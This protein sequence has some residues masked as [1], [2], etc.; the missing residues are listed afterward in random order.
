MAAMAEE[1]VEKRK[2]GKR[3]ASAPAAIPL[4]AALSATVESPLG[5]LLVSANEDAVLALGWTGQERREPAAPLLAEA[6]RQLSAYFAGRLTRF[7][8]PLAPEGSS[9]DQRVRRA[10]CAIPYG[11]TATYGAIA[12]A[13]GS[14][15][16][17]VGGACGRNP[18]PILIPCHR[19]VAGAGLGG[20][21]GGEGLTTKA[22]L[23]AFEG[24]RRAGR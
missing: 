2:F 14:S 7:D 15:P 9:F 16:R 6:V 19:I 10:M 20:Y 3:A 13:I 11:E 4:S 12:R 18:V 17:A 24:A 5:R 21:S 22:W 8:L 23:L 1:P